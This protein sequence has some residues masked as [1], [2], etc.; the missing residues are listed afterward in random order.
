MFSPA[1]RPASCFRGKDIFS[2]YNFL[3]MYLKNDECP[4]A[5]LSPDGQTVFP[6][7]SVHVPPWICPLS[8]SLMGNQAVL[9]ATS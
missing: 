9:Q 1:I 4:E 6:S 3:K 7:A 8:V 5:E 2:N